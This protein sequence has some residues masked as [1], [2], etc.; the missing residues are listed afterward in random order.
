MDYREI[1][2]VGGGIAG[3]SL[4]CHLEKKQ[5]PYHLFEQAPIFNPVGAGILLANNAMQVFQRLGIAETL[6]KKANR[7]SFLNLVDE[8]LN[9]LSSSNLA[10]FE[11]QYGVNNIAIHRADLHA[12]LLE[13]LDTEKVHLNKQVESI[14]N[15]QIHFSD[16][17]QHKFE[18]LIGADGIHSKVR[19]SIFGPGKIK[20]AGQVCWRGVVDYQLPKSMI[21]QFNEAWGPGIRFGFAQINKEQ[22]YWFALCKY[23]RSM[24]EWDG[25]NWKKEF[26]SYHPIV[27]DL[28]KL[29]PDEAIHRAEISQLE[30]MNKWYQ[31]DV[32]LIG[33]ACH[34]MTPNMGQ[35]AGQGIEDAYI[36]AHCLGTQTPEEAFK[37]YESMRLAKV[38]SIVNI[39]WQIGRVAQLDSALGRKLRNMI[40][41][42]TPQKLSQRQVSKVIELAI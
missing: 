1:S 34:A 3:L 25:K 31:D 23:K 30:W 19:E 22:V 10:S 18:I 26:N 14:S 29:T 36:L 8:Q 2:I 39:S 41:R 20:E 35:G 9:V 11:K 24:S 40:L 12:T 15:H 32:C 33:D 16:G 21:D 28:L 27:V 4:A 6:S 17:N 37:N 38:K 13:Q 5:I 7:I 42:M